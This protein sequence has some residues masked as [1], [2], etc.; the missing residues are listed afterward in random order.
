MHFNSGI[1]N[2]DFPAAADNG[3]RIIIY[4][5]SNN[6]TNYNPP[7]YYLFTVIKYCKNE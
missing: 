6:T 1:L 2:Y 4:I 7:F 5:T 3:L